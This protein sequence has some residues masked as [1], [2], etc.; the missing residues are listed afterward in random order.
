MLRFKTVPSGNS[1]LTTWSLNGN[2]AFATVLE[3]MFIFVGMIVNLE[4]NHLGRLAFAAHIV[5]QM[6][7]EANIAHETR[8][9]KLVVQHGI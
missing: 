7:H 8:K 2:F 5:E 3:T 4:L 9:V 6:N 1:R